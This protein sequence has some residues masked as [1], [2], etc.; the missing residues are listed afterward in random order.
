ML[1]VLLTLVIIGVLLYAVE[2]YVPMSP[3]I[4][5]LIRIVVVLCVVIWLLRVFG[6]ADLPVPQL[7]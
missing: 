1:A 6:V 5:L 3:P 2:T 7:R 4:K